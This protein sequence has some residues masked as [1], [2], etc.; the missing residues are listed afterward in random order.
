MAD[1]PLT[2]VP[3]KNQKT[4]DK[5][6]VSLQVRVWF[7][8]V[9]VH[10]E[11]STN[12]LARRFPST[13]SGRKKEGATST[14]ESGY[15]YQVRRGEHLPLRRRHGRQLVDEVEAVFPHTRRWIVS[16][17]WRLLGTAAIDLP[18]IH[19]ILG[20]LHPRIRDFLFIRPAVGSVFVR[21]TPH[22][23]QYEKLDAVAR[24]LFPK[25][26]DDVFERLMGGVIAVLALIREAELIYQQPL[27]VQGRKALRGMVERLR[28]F[29]E[30]EKLSAEL[31]ELG[32][33]R[34]SGTVYSPDGVGSMTVQL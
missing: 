26:G 27:H 12:E 9:K 16:P 20:G 32:Q 10:S 28:C 24:P 11:L 21:T 7:N 3:E 30:L 25:D 6:V 31:I 34:F 18:E 8:A 4:F 33:Q 29:P 23:G 15:W 17:L 22:K 5:A 14:S 13:D 19:R 2:L 1:F